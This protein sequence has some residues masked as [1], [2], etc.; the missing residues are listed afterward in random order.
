MSKTLPELRQRLSRAIGD[1]ISETVTTAI[2][3]STS[4]ISTSLLKYTNKDDY[5]NRWWVLI[6]SLANIG[7]VRKITDYTASTGANTVLGSNLTSDGASLATFEVHKYDPDNYTNAL[8]NAARQLNDYLFRLVED[9][10]VATDG[11][12]YEFELPTS[13]QVGQLAWVYYY[14]DIE[15]HTITGIS[16]AA[17]TIVTTSDNHNL[18]TGDSV[19]IE[20]SNSTPTIDGTRTVTVLSSTTFSIPVTVT[21]AGTKG[22]VSNKSTVESRREPIWGWSIV[23]ISGTKYL[24]VPN[25]NKNKLCLV[26]TTPLES[27]LSSETSTMTIADPYIDLLVAYAAY[28]LYEMEAGSPSA[29][30]REFLKNEASYWLGKTEYLKRNCKMTRPQIQTRFR[31]I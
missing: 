1:Y 21:V 19:I 17:S 26:G 22:N 28:Q 23:D 11:E 6:T 10:T 8:N 30:D 7:V 29:N 2:A 18:T 16:V 12:S 4:V 31:S 3:A 9:T 13:F 27:N 20:S 24:R 25:L 15:V 5:F 14:P